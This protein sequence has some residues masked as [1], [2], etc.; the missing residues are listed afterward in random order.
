MT[1][2][3]ALVPQQQDLRKQKRL[4]LKAFFLTVCAA[5]AS[6]KVHIRGSITNGS[7]SAGGG[8][9]WQSAASGE[10]DFQPKSHQSGSQ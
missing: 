6:T 7:R 5:A 3:V 4:Y 2:L 8:M 9:H 10:A 1:S